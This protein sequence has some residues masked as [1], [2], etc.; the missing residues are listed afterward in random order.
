MAVPS[1]HPATAPPVAPER[2]KTAHLLLRGWCVVIL[3]LS[4]CG[5]GVALVFGVVATAALAV[6]AA[7]VSAVLWML[8]RPAVQYRRLPWF[9]VAVTAWAGLSV[10][11]SPWPGASAV[12]WA[13]LVAAGAQG[14]F[15]A[16]V[17]SWRDIVRALASSLK[18]LLGASLAVE[19]WAA[20][21]RPAPTSGLFTLGPISGMTGDADVFA[22]LCLL[23]VIVFAVRF[24]AR[25]PRRG[26]LIAWIAL[27]A[28]LF[29]HAGSATGWLTALF[30]GLVLATASLMRTA[31]HPGERTRYY[32]VFIAA[33]LA[34][35]LTVWLAW[36]PMIAAFGGTGELTGGVW[37]AASATLGP[38]GVALLALTVLAYVWRAWFF[39]V[40]RPRYDLV[41]DRPYSP[42]ALLPTLVGALLLVQSVTAA[43]P[44]TLWGWMLLVLLAAKIK[45]VPLVG[46]GI[47][48]QADVRERT[49]GDL[50]A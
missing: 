48:E 6:V 5:T 15:V 25:A 50:Q 20:L 29:V 21:F 19:A 41:A 24:A 32:V 35:A 42:L 8:L 14:I 12:V 47:A 7:L 39:G 1:K 38:V 44:V 28:V 34:L 22:A 13:L 49:S 46:V 17:L 30:A 43:G 10:A 3:L 11:A 9:A 23:A 18:W 4:F 16:A 37:A 27:A 40:D 26:W 33:A 31:A 2:E 36:T 45:Q